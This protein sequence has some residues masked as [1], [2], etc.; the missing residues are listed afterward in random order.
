[1]LGRM[2]AAGGALIAAAG[3]WTTWDL[4]RPLPTTGFGGRVRAI[5][6]AAVPDEALRSQIEA[7]VDL[8]AEETTCPACLAPVPGGASKCPGCLLRF[9]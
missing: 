7:V 5:A 3:T 1:M 2:W 8:D 4:L 9:G 6:A